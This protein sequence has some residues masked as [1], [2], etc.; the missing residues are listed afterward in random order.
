MNAI[1]SLIDR[2]DR[3]I[4]AEV[5]QQ[6]T[7]WAELGRANRERGSRLRR[8]E[9]EAQHIIEL[10]KLRLEAFLSRFKAVVKAEPMVREHTR[11]VNL[12]F[13]ATVANVT[14]RF[15][16]FPDQHVNHI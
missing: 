9:A 14:L 13:A 2:I 3:E 12:S 10:V 4:T 8:Y 1:D 11:A 7:G 6:K 16:V 15:E 5:E